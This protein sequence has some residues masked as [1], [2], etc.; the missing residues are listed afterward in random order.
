MILINKSN[1]IIPKTRVM[2]LITLKNKIELI[3]VYNN[4]NNKTKSNKLKSYQLIKKKL[5]LQKN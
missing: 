5:N 4:N 2:S 1:Q 3:K